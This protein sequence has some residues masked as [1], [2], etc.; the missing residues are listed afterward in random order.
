LTRSGRLLR[1]SAIECC[2]LTAHL[3]Y[4]SMYMI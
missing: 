4:I 1:A 3:V 2:S